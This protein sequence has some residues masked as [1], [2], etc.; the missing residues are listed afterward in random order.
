M[1]HSEAKASCPVWQQSTETRKA[2][3]Y[4][5]MYVKISSCGNFPHIAK[6]IVGLEFLLKVSQGGTFQC[7]AKCILSREIFTN[8]KK[9][10]SS[11]CISE[12][13][14]SFMSK[15]QH[16]DRHHHSEARV[17]LDVKA[18]LGKS[19]FQ[20]PARLSGILSANRPNHQHQKSSL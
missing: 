20:A 18:G 1:C 8:C 7:I 13:I 15:F 4:V 19:S 12:Q 14:I 9:I 10:C 16:R 11:F 17:H 2:G 6:N 5:K 3:I